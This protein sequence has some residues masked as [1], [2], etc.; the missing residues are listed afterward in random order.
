MESIELVRYLEEIEGF[1]SFL[2]FCLN[3]WDVSMFIGG[4]EEVNREGSAES[5]WE[6][7]NIWEGVGGKELRVLG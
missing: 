1:R 2:L 6:F 7:S 4:E 3:M 5:I